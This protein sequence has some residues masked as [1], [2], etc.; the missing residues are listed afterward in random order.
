MTKKDVMPQV[1]IPPAMQAQMDADPAL[2]AAMRDMSA[3]MKDAMQGVADGRYKSFDD[4]MEAMTG[5]R[6]E[7]VQPPHPPKHGYYLSCDK[8]PKGD[9]YMAIITDGHPKAGHIDIVIHD[10]EI[11]PSVKAARRWYRRRCSELPWEDHTVE[12][13]TGMGDE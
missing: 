13:V 7:K 5:S 10:M 4:A 8:N 3:T 6:P 9:G 11:F 12:E 2:A 1:V